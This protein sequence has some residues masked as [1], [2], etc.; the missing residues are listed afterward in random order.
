MNM[1]E[2]IAR[3]S[4]DALVASAVIEEEQALADALVSI[5]QRYGKFN[6][7]D[8]GVWAGYESA[9]EN[10]LAD[11]GV[12]C[13]NCILYEGG[14][15]CK[16]IAAEVEPGGYCRFALIPDG[17][18][19]AAG[20]KRAPKKDRIYG[21]K[22]NKPGSAAGGKKITFSAK[23][24]KALSNK[25]KEHNEKAPAG[26]KVTLGMLK[27]V[28][29]RGAGA[30]SS[31]HRPG[32]TRDQW[33]MARVNAYLRLVKSGR[34]ANSNYKQDNDLLPKAHPKS[35]NAT[36][37]ITASAIASAELIIA[38]KEENEYQSPEHAIVAFAEYSGLGYEVIPAFR[39]AWMRAVDDHE[40]PFERAQELAINLYSSRDADLLPKEYSDLAVAETVTAA[41]PGGKGWRSAKAKLQRRDRYGRFAEMGGGFSFVFKGKG[42]SPSR[43]TGRVVGQSGTDDVD[44]EVKGSDALPDGTYSLPSAKGEAV[45]AIISNDALKQSGVDKG[46]AKSTFPA[47]TPMVSDKDIK[48]AKD[49]QR[50]GPIDDGLPV[51]KVKSWTDAELE[52][53][54]RRYDSGKEQVEPE[55]LDQIDKELAK[56]RAEKAERLEKDRSNPKNWK[57]VQTSIGGSAGYWEYTGPTKNFPPEAKDNPAWEMRNLSPPS[58][59]PPGFAGGKNVGLPGLPKDG[60]DDW[61]GVKS[62]FNRETI[63]PDDLTRPSPETVAEEMKAIADRFKDM[64]KDE[65]RE[66]QSWVTPLRDKNPKA[67]PAPPQ[68]KETPEPTTEKAETEDSQYDYTP[69]EPYEIAAVDEMAKSTG[70]PRQLLNNLILAGRIKNPEDAFYLAKEYG[71]SEDKVKGLINELGKLQRQFREKE[72]G[73][74][75]FVPGDADFLERLD[76]SQERLDKRRL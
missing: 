10:E 74:P 27:A 76:K 53:T 7:D 42:K 23:T 38:L 36:E 73:K 49:P 15:S 41:F 69:R 32:K 6:S 51:S 65:G 14:T 20:S 64:L 1:Q 39:A 30:F 55:L 60:K 28:Y 52:K 18:V 67:A 3:R 57:W 72:T 56:R 58:G 68:V 29:R 2:R 54:R 17:V 37:A 26:R 34:P 5:T 50:K 16:I 19:T 24:E 21:S 4:V 31:S 35:T 12:K 9:D 46:K 33:A 40:V 8:T 59:L 71:M 45:K 62:P 25:V 66:S 13:A 11:I 61:Y 44:V 43:V 22:K 70:L 75:I 63:N 47:D 48:A